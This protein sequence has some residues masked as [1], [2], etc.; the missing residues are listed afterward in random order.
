MTFLSR[1]SFLLN[2]VPSY[3]DQHRPKTN[4]ERPQGG[5]PEM[6]G[7]FVDVKQPSFVMSIMFLSSFF[8]LPQKQPTYQT[9]IKLAA[10]VPTLFPLLPTHMRRPA[11]LSRRRGG[12]QVAPREEGIL[13]RSAPSR[14]TPAETRYLS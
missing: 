5:P 11:Q 9:E 2:F 4:P 7:R 12:G 8:F 14:A 6:G 10:S 1:S 13:R 3:F